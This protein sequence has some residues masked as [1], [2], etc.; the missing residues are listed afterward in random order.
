MCHI[1]RLYVRIRSQK[2]E[3]TKMLDY[4]INLTEIIMAN[5]ELI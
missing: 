5:G 1:R 4:F 3:T 2:L